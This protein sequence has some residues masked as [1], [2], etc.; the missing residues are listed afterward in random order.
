MS[1]KLNLYDKRR[2][3]TKLIQRGGDDETYTV[4]V[5]A[6]PDKIDTIH[7]EV[8]DFLNKNLPGAVN[9][10]NRQKVT[11]ITVPRKMKGEIE[12]E[13][14]DKKKTNTKFDFKPVGMC[15]MNC[16]YMVTSPIGE[17]F[18][19]SIFKDAGIKTTPVP[20]EYR[21]KVEISSDNINT[22][23]YVAKIYKLDV[24]DSKGTPLSPLN[25]DEFKNLDNKFTRPTTDIP[26]EKVIELKAI[27]FF[28]PRIVV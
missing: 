21:L 1:R 27:G 24:K 25:D 7:N 4:T 22:L 20:S 3:T 13:L 11:K 14:L 26:F 12:T 10:E 15:V 9:E 2:Y 17:N 23:K 8:V 5:T 19:S 16:D 6:K 18:D 28:A